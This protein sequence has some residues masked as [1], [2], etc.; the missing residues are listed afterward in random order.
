MVLVRGGQRATPASEPRWRRRTAHDVAHVASVPSPRSARRS[1]AIA[2]SALSVCALALAG[3]AVA[4][5]D[6]SFSLALGAGCEE[7][8]PCLKLEAE[9]ERRLLDCWVACRHEVLDHKLARLLRYKAEERNQ[10]RDHYRQR[11]AA[12]QALARAE[13]QRRLDDWQREQTARQRA[14]AIEHERRLELERL[15]REHIDS[16]VARERAR[17]VAYLTLLG[18]DGRRE[19]LR[20]CHAK[21]AGCEQ[22]VVDLVE[23]AGDP[24]EQRALAE[25]EE[26]LLSGLPERPIAPRAALAAAEKPTADE[27]STVTEQPAA[28]QP[29]AEPTALV[30]APSP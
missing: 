2:L 9:A 24:R 17:R 28:E 23:A 16:S 4:S 13:E 19:R 6:S 26:R 25:L 27:R 21:S 18:A 7:L 5:R 14:S 3:F 20:R 30:P 12:E 29:A 10:V 22:L 8:E 1:W 15:R 11:D